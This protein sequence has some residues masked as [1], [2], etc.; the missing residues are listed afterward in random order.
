VV[1]VIG[2]L[3]TADILAALMLASEH[4]QHCLLRA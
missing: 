3:T 4:D 2:V 1:C